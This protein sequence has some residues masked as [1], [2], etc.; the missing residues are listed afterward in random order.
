M[1]GPLHPLLVG[2]VLA[3]GGLDY[4]LA[5][6]PS[7]TAWV[8]TALFA[9]LAARRAV[10]Q[11]GNLAGLA[12]ALFVLASP[13]HQAFAT[14]IM[15]ESL[16]ACLSL[17][18]L[19]ACLVAVQERSV[20]SGRLLGLALTLLFFHKYNYWLLAVL[21]LAGAALA[22]EPRRA[23]QTLQ[24]FRARTSWRE[25]LKGQLRHPLTYLLVPMVL[26]LATVFW[27]GGGALQIGSRQ[28]SLNTPHNVVHVAF[29]LLVLRVLPWWWR[30]GRSWVR[31][32]D[33]PAR[34]LVAWH[35][36]PGAAMVPVAAAARLL[37]LVPHARPWAGPGRGAASA[38]SAY[39][40]HSLSTDYHLDE[41]GLLIALVLAGFAPFCPGAGYGRAAW[42]CWGSCWRPRR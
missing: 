5:V 14:D 37:S 34:Q 28:I 7:L 39:Y 12:A 8:G 41:A 30:T 4:R 36:A 38:G 18:A 25:W 1:W 40:W 24:T 29:V 15:L 16:G 26:F 21:P 17:A 42:S 3:I 35:L 9:F 23:L 32:L 20:W 31:Q 33:P 13:A 22:A 19:Y 2:L 10:P 27:H 6:L 11:G